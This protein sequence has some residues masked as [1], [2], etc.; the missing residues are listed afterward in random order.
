MF[1]VKWSETWKKKKK[2]KFINRF[3]TSRKSLLK[4]NNL[5]GIFKQSVPLLTRY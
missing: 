5:E 4:I 1:K 3:K 2:K